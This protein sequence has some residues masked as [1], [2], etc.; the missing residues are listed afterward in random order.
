MSDVEDPITKIR[1]DLAKREQL[2]TA[3]D[4]AVKSGAD[5]FTFEQMTFVVHYA[6]YV[7]QYLDA[8]L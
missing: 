4:A 1:F 3:Y 7:L 2:R 8:R 5:H 6:K